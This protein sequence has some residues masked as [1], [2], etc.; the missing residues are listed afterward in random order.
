MAR[1][2]VLAENPVTRPL[3]RALQ[4][5][6]LVEGRAGVEGHIIHYLG[7]M[8][9]LL[10][11]QAPCSE[12]HAHRVKFGLGAGVEP[13]LHARVEARFGAESV[14]SA[15]PA[16]ADGCRTGVWRASPT[17][18]PRA[19]CCSREVPVDRSGHHS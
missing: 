6:P 2:S 15:D 10:L 7:V 11:N 9:P 4:P 19:G 1:R 5:R 17:S 12:E 3:R 8:P 14:V 13:E 16:L 18:R